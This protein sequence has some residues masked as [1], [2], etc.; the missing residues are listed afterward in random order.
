MIMFYKKKF[1]ILRIYYDI[2]W[3]L[4]IISLKFNTLKKNTLLRQ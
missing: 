1:S 3:V 4:F 2:F